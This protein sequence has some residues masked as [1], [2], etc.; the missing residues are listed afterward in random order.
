MTNI[1]PSTRVYPP[2]IHEAESPVAGCFAVVAKHPDRA[3][4]A[5]RHEPAVA[6]HDAREDRGELSAVSRL[7]EHARDARAHAL[8]L[9]L[10]GM[11]HRLCTT[12]R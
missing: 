7:G 8:W 3:L 2:C 12:Q 4:L 6:D 5:L 11:L 9:V 10:Q 1:S